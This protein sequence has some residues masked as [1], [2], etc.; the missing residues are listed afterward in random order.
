MS[1]KKSIKGA[2]AGV[3]G[4]AMMV[5][6][7]T[8]DVSAQT[9]EEA[10]YDQITS[11]V[12]DIE[13][14]EFYKDH[15]YDRAV[16]KSVKVN[17]ASH[18]PS[19]E[20]IT[21]SMYELTAS[22]AK[23]A[24]APQVVVLIVRDPNDDLTLRTGNR[25]SNTAYEQKIIDM[26]TNVS[27]SFA[28]PQARVLLALA[29]AQE[30]KIK[31]FPGDVLFYVNNRI[32]YFSPGSERYKDLDE[33]RFIREVAMNLGRQFAGDNYKLTR[34][35]SL[36]KVGLSRNA[37]TEGHSSSGDGTGGDA[38]GSGDKTTHPLV[39]VADNSM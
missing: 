18:F 8:T 12:D 26:V 9:P 2:L 21:Q 17:F 35:E 1:F 11:L 31:S 28:D 14:A 3:A 7:G 36:E 34:S 4:V 27:N 39:A 24:S 22:V 32:S 13:A 30:E 10:D 23:G 38:G 6:V 15:G 33:D 25:F 29:V 5:A 19:G 20:A 37:P 16:Q